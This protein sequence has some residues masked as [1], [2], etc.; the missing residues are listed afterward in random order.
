MPAMVVLLSALLAALA[1]P[2]AG[3]CPTPDPADLP[4]R[5]AAAQC[6]ATAGRWGVAAQHYTAIVA[7]SP[8]HP[9]AEASLL[10]LVRG[11][12]AIA[13]FADAAGHAER[14]AERY[15]RQR[16][17]PDL[18][19]EAAQVR[20]ALGDRRAALAD[21][22]RVEMLLQRSDPARAADVF[23]ARRTLLTR[24]DERL[25]HAETFLKRYSR[26][27]DDR[28]VVAEVTIAAIAWARACPVPTRHGLC[29]T[30]A[31]PVKKAARCGDG[32]P[33]R[34]VARDRARADVAQRRLTA[35]LRLAAVDPKLP[36]D[37][38]QRRRE[39][40]D[41]VATAGLH[42]AD[43]K[44][45]ELLALHPPTG[46]VF[47]VDETLR[48]SDPRAYA[49]QSERRSDS[50][51]RFNAYITG[52]HKLAQ[53]LGDRYAEVAA[54]RRGARATIAARARGGLVAQH[55]AD[56]LLAIEI[57]GDIRGPDLTKAFCGELRRHTD[58]LREQ[59]AA[60]FGACV[61]QASALGEWDDAARLCEDAAQTLDPRTYP[62]LHELFAPG[63]SA[64]VPLE[65]IEL[66]QDATPF[67]S[68]DASGT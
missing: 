3:E 63:P 66:Q 4:A 10:R 28:R 24:D 38:V 56:D 54:A 43:Q 42:V 29:V 19:I 36:A 30:D 25:T 32:T 39:Y 45:E 68:A 49:R 46:L 40:E 15:P 51:R 34:V 60:A 53:Q 50:L 37:Q 52:T 7:A 48:D 55:L 5:F 35:V 16:E 22:D 8:E 27:G 13:R 23:W 31:A 9:L 64:I 44:F 33:L 12:L 61:R 67:M 65:Q 58:G 1:G 2:T 59:A 21:L 62:E 41:A 26:A 47:S 57:P 20:L 6:H 14:Y 18:L 11:D 17:A